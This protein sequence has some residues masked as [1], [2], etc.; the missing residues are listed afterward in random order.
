VAKAS[1]DLSTWTS[2]KSPWCGIC[3]DSSGP[4]G[5]ISPSARQADAPWSISK[6]ISN[7]ACSSTLLKK[8]NRGAES[9][10]ANR[11]GETKPG[12]DKPFVLEQ[13]LD[14]VSRFNTA[15]DRGRYAIVYFV[16]SAVF[17]SFV[18]YDNRELMRVQGGSQ[19]ES[20]LPN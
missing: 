4:Q 1:G 13:Y 2:K 5:R 17:E 19:T 6:T 8:G 20:R 12:D 9:K 18:K 10:D 15:A 14:I 7:A 3:D 16:L 11:R